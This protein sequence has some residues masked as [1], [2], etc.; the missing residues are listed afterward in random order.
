MGGNDA[1]DFHHTE[2]GFGCAAIFFLCV[3][4]HLDLFY[5][6]WGGSARRSL[7]D[8]V[9]GSVWEG[10]SNSESYFF[11]KQVISEAVAHT[12]G[13]GFMLA[14]LGMIADKTHDDQSDPNKHYALSTLQAWAIVPGIAIYVCTMVS[15]TWGESFNIRAHLPQAICDGMIPISW[16]ALGMF[17]SLH[18]PYDHKRYATGAM[19]GLAFSEIVLQHTKSRGTDD[20]FA[21]AGWIF[22]RTVSSMIYATSIIF[23]VI[24]LCRKIEP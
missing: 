11:S 17:A 9:P 12:L 1:G 20:S 13:W 19:V 6:K 18:R 15:K 16:V 8:L 2:L 14:A 5:H 24:A 22:G 3:A 7:Y 10:A 23:F 4:H 21:A